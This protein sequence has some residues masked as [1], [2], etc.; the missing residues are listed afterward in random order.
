MGAYELQKYQTSQEP[1][2]SVLPPSPVAGALRFPPSLPV[3]VK[4]RI[5]EPVAVPSAVGVGHVFARLQVP[6][7]CGQVQTWR[8]TALA[9]H[10][11]PRR[12]IGILGERG[13]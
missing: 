10:L 13:K 9:L 12:G 2:S 6:A 1:H 8:R 11:V 7:L 3:E 5:R 4:E